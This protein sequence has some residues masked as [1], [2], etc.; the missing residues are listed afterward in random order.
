M[1]F[2]AF[3]QADG[4]ATRKYGGTGLGLAISAQLVH[5]MKGE[6]RVESTPGEGSV[7][8]FNCRFDL[9]A[10]ASEPSRRPKP[11]H[12]NAMRV[13]VVDDNATNRRVLKG[14]LSGWRMA[15]TLVDSGQ[16]A[17]AEMRDALD[18]GAPYLLVILDV[19]M[20]EMDGFEV[21]SEIRKDPRL[22]QA[23]IMMLSSATRQGDALRCRE[24]G[25][26]QYLVKPVGQ[27]AML[28]SIL[29]VLGTGGR[30][31]FTRP[32][33]TNWKPVQCG[34]LNILLA[35][36]NAVNRRLAVR[37]LE[38]AGHSVQVACNGK[39][40]LDAWLSR[41]FDL[42]LMDVQM[43]EMDGFETVAEIRRHECQNP[44][45]RPVPVI[46]LTA[47]AMK[48]DRERCLAAGMDGYVSKPVR[49]TTLFRTIESVLQ[50]KG[51]PQP[52]DE[53]P[54]SPPKAD[55]RA[56]PKTPSAF[57]LPA[58]LR[59]LDGDLD[60]LA[61]LA[62]LFL[63]TG[64]AM[65]EEIRRALAD[66]NLEAVARVAHTLKSSAGNFD[67][68]SVFEAAMNLDMA[69]RERDRP[70]VEKH[71]ESLE[72]DVAA[73]ANELAAYANARP[74]ADRAGTTG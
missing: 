60:L 7:F 42:I 26:A 63:E 54:A 59:R 32:D 47:H 2:G 74:V 72:T 44:Q 39:E 4:S 16:A 67:A 49:R 61:E 45:G 34:P 21:A 51:D 68:R 66:D 40:A 43:P 25:I 55:S 6:I 15:P 31:V 41:P 1:I 30:D 19:N 22:G 18:V 62:G 53:S 58:A 69:A 70:A 65:M 50:G 8:H 37:V 9:Q 14:M 71:W 46:A 36:D 33:P 24:I 23:I 28:D 27:S 52:K 35:E 20:P 17:L 5:M 13:L 73:L 48:D 10:N 3:E 11:I 38:K 57:D 56:L 29:T 64:P 12:L